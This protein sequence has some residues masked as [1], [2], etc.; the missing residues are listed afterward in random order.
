[1]LKIVNTTIS[2]VNVVHLGYKRLLR[3]LCQQVKNT[4]TFSSLILDSLHHL[5][6]MIYILIDILFI[7]LIPINTIYYIFIG[8]LINTFF[9]VNFLLTMA[10]PNMILRP[11]STSKYVL[12]K[13]INTIYKILI[14]H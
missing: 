14:C 1:M 8:I 5:I 10:N 7:C 9:F 12:S 2:L 4:R 3:S 11:K 13:D 6:N